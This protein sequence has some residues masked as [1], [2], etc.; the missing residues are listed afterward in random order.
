MHDN[1][2][3]NES[4]GLE[5][6]EICL[7]ETPVTNGLSALDRRVLGRADVV[8][9]DC[10]LAPLIADVRLAS[11]YAEPLST[12]AKEGAPAISARALKLASEGWRVVQLVQPCHPWRRRL[13]GAAEEL[14]RL[15]GTRELAIRLIAKTATDPSQIQDARLCDLPEL[16]DSAA[17]DEPLTVIVGPLAGGASAAVYAITANG[18]AG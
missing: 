2:W 8:L 16:V 5:P 10:A 3:S 13:R 6:G 15:S 1:G 14:G 9:Y 18:L 4:P 11:S 12:E 17:E 7:I